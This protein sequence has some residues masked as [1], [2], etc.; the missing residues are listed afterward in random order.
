[1]PLAPFVDLGQ[2]IFIH[3]RQD[4]ARLLFVIRLSVL[5]VKLGQLTGNPINQALHD[6][7]TPNWCGRRMGATPLL[8][9]K[10]PAQ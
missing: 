6:T 7:H 10:Y 2:A 4:D 9:R 5:P 3:D 1:M 8:R